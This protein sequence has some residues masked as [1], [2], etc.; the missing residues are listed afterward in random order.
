MNPCYISQTLAKH[1]RSKSGSQIDTHESELKCNH[2]HKIVIWQQT[3][4][5]IQR[6]VNKNGLTLTCAI[7]SIPTEENRN[8]LSYPPFTVIQTLLLVQIFITL[9]LFFQNLMKV[10]W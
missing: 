2:V 3:H 8:V 7:E 5:F 4:Y 9:I 1:H 6:Y 10:Y